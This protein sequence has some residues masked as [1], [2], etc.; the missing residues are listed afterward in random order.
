M[1][2]LALLALAS[3][4]AHAAEEAHTLLAGDF[5]DAFR[6][7]D[8]R[9]MA[10]LAARPALD[11]PYTL[12]V[13]E[14]LRRGEPE[15]AGR[16]AELRGGP[17]REGLRRLVDRYREGAVP[18]PAQLAAVERAHAHL[19]R[20]EGAA[21]LQALQGAGQPAKETLLAAE[22][23][24]VRARA[25]EAEGRTADAAA[26][27]GDCA[28]ASV[29]IGWLSRARSAAQRQLALAP[30]PPVAQRLVELNRRL[31]DRS[32]LV[33]AL[34]QQASVLLAA[35][36][37]EG[38][39][40]AYGD[41]IQLA[42]QLEDPLRAA[43]LLGELAVVRHERA[44]L[45]P[46]LALDSY[47]ESLELYRSLGVRSRH[48]QATFLNAARAYSQLARYAESLALLDE[49]LGWP[50]DDDVGRRAFRQRAYVLRRQ[51]RREESL[52]AYAAALAAAEGDAERGALHAEMGELE[53]ERFDLASAT[54]HF[55]AVL[56]VSPEDPHAL[57]GR[58][59]ACLD[60]SK[61]LAGFEAAIGH[62][63]D[64]ERRVLLLSKA[65]FERNWGRLD[66]A[67]ASVRASLAGLDEKTKV[68]LA[69]VAIGRKMLADLLLVDRAY[70]EAL[71]ELEKASV[72]FF[73]LDQP[74]H[75]IPAYM[76]ETLVLVHLGR[77]EDAQR[78]LVTL[79]GLAAREPDEALKAMAARADAALAAG[80]GRPEDAVALLNDA[81]D[82]AA[83]GGDAQGQAAALVHRALLDPAAGHSLVRDALA[84][85][86]ARPEEALAPHPFVEGEHPLHACGIGVRSLLESG[87]D[88]ARAWPLMERA[89]LE[90]LQLALRGREM[91]LAAALPAELHRAWV[92]CR[93][94]LR[95]A[96]VE[97][98][99]EVEAER[100]LRAFVARLRG[101][102]PRVAAIAFPE[103]PPLGR[104]QEALGEEEALLL[105]LADEYARAVLF[106]DRG[107]AVVAPFE[108]GKPLDAVAPLLEGKKRLIVAPDD[109]LMLESPL[110]VRYVPAATFLVLPP[111][112]GEGSLDVREPLRADL[113][114]PQAS[115]MPLG[116]RFEAATVVLRDLSVDRG[117]RPG[118]DGV[119]ALFAGFWLGG[120]DAVELPLGGTAVRWGA[121]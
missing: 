77:L 111:S 8:E 21:A 79:R 59:A 16:L 120:A 61:A 9:R 115:T 19:A 86:D 85:L 92:A 48:A 47:R 56:R 49:L 105:F 3:V 81:F 45:S 121:R 93:G 118:V 87:G 4:A 41:A 5:L 26:A 76:R 107:R 60:E 108:P 40:K 96:R 2:L 88:A 34:A 78:R 24:L 50:P 63:P 52:A 94:R 74:R 66:A 112:G 70:E 12:A 51:E 75:A 65:A 32:G 73:R 119:G 37:A 80:S 95:E 44:G 53:L 54:A 6:G 97:K 90:R 103:P 46:K 62:A 83:K 106:V 117:P 69:N 99:G 55:D 91:F 104:V 15:A 116:R 1:R 13:Y 98:E 58:A 113:T 101:E 109:F 10:V 57:A 64:A 11:V 31:D 33:N 39:Q 89:R 18:E 22:I 42:K 14:L 17:E 82:L 100:D 27:W 38:A 110:E 36:D 67:R 20:G 71:P 114:H 23:H 29:E 7:H 72:L 25:F 28:N 68:D 35:G 102:A 30:A 84:I 43:G